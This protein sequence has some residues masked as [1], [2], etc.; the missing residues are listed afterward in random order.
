MFPLFLSL[1]FSC[2]VPLGPYAPP[3]EMQVPPTSPTV[4]VRPPPSRVFGIEFFFPLYSVEFF[5]VVGTAFVWFPEDFVLRVRFWL[6]C[7]EIGSLWGYGPD[8]GEWT[9]FSCKVPYGATS[10]DRSLDIHFK[11]LHFFPP[12]PFHP[13]Y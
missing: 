12:P 1:S 9:H 5:V 3:S 10:V 13:Q 6:T 4:F 2:S 11:S 7:P 8:C